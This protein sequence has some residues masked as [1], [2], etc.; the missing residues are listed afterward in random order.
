MECANG[1]YYI[2][3]V[4]E[5]EESLEKMCSEFSACYGRLSPFMSQISVTLSG[6]SLVLLIWLLQFGWPFLPL[7]LILESSLKEARV[8]S[9]VRMRSKANMFAG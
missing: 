6:R 8:F 1:D 4:I 3:H 7:F 5:K 2:H 9:E